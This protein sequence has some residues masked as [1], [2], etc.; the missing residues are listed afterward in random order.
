M[1]GAAPE[2]ASGLKPSVQHAAPLDDFFVAI[3]DGDLVAAEAFVNENSERV[4]KK[5]KQVQCPPLALA[6]RYGKMEILQML[7]A[8]NADL[9]GEDEEGR[10][11]LHN[12]VE[13]GNAE[14]ALVLA[15]AL[16]GR[17][18]L[19]PM[20]RKDDRQGWTVL[21]LAARQGMVG[22]VTY[23]AAVENAPLD[24]VQRATGTTGLTAM[25]CAATRGHH[26]VVQEL[27]LAKADTAIVNAKDG[28][29]DALML[30]AM[31]GHLEVVQ[32][33][34]EHQANASAVDDTGMTAAHWALMM[35]HEDVG[36]ELLR[37]CGGHD[38]ADQQGTTPQ[39]LLDELNEGEEEER[40]A[41][42]DLDKCSEETKYA[43]ATRGG[44]YNGG[45][46]D[47]EAG[48]Y[49]ANSYWQKDYGAFVLSSDDDC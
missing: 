44:G 36:K 17:K 9:I 39:A 42:P 12:A 2:T 8:K 37:R 30:A 22:L 21:P 23:L 25:M 3:R 40:V 20:L 1:S 16:A 46:V 35:E 33:L 4:D 24:D 34:L 6:A 28:Q 32:V 26:K 47:M 5:V 14:C 19:R 48:S 41:S 15:E 10:S 49:A 29:K 13:G 38:V 43:V 18:W 27:C 11:A 45:L 31:N 7:L